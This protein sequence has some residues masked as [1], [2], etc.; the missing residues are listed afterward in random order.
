MKADLRGRVVLVTGGT[1]GIG[2]ATGLAF[3]RRGAHVVLTHRWGSADEGAIRAAFEATDAPAPDIVEA[4]VGAPEDTEA[5]VAHLRERH[6]RVHAFVS[7]VAFAQLARSKEDLTLRALNR[8]IAYTAWPLVDYSLALERAFGEWPRY[9]VGVSSCGAREHHTSY[10]LAGASKA[11]LEALVRY[12]AHRT[13]ST[14]C[15]VNAV[16]PRWVDT[17]SLAATMGEGFVPFVKANAH[18]DPLLQTPEE[19]ADVVVALCSGWLDGMRGQVIDVDRGT[20]FYDNMMRLYANRL[21][22]E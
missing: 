17:A 14:P 12:L 11:A 22:T 3:G 9:V 15:R 19:V 21:R 18:G 8:S 16:R 20:G 7:N 2:L 10:D 1:A 4:D 13:A 5:L 6:E